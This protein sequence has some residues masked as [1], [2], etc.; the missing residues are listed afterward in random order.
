MSAEDLGGAELHCATSGVA[1]HLAESE[2]HAASLTRRVLANLGAGGAPGDLRSQR[3]PN[4]LI[5]RRAVKMLAQ[6]VRVLN[7]NDKMLGFR[8]DCQALA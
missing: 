3:E 4:I 6:R 5:I 7:V 8:H 2:A 1:D